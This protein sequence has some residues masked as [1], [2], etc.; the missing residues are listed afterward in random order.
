MAANGCEPASIERALRVI[1]GTYP[2]R[3]VEPSI[4]TARRSARRSSASASE[5]RTVLVAG[6]GQFPPTLQHMGGDEALPSRALAA[7]W[8]WRDAMAFQNI[9]DRLIRD[10]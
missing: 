7:F 10:L 1:I 5:S 6:S 8:R 2:R 9:S 3:I 4:L